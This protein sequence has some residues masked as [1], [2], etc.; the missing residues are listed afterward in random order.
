MLLFAG[1]NSYMYET[2]Y[3][4]DKFFCVTITDD[5]ISL[6]VMLFI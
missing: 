4:T 3:S 2:I 5:I 1:M 6:R